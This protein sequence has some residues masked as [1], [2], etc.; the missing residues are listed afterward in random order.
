MDK[1]AKETKKLCKHSISGGCKFGSACNSWHPADAA[2]A[3]AEQKAKNT[4]NVC[5]FHPRCTDPGCTFLHVDLLPRGTPSAG[6]PLASGGGKPPARQAPLGRTPV[7]P[8][9]SA[10]ARPP[11]RMIMEKPQ[12]TSKR[13]DDSRGRPEAP[14]GQKTRPEKRQGTQATARPQVRQVVEIQ[15]K[16][17][18][19]H[20]AGAAFRASAEALPGSFATELLRK[21][22]QAAE[23]RSVALTKLAE[24]S[25]V[26]DEYLTFLGASSEAGAPQVHSETSASPTSSLESGDSAEEPEDVARLALDEPDAPAEEDDADGDF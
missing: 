16:L 9:S 24:I 20:E 10:V 12:E 21:A 18:Q 7:R 19:L 26:L 4:L 22:D 2:V 13:S 3:I 23:M 14:R 8:L 17:Q 11:Q 25:S 15:Q 5:S 1:K 6:T